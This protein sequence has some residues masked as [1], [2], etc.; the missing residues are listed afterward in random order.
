[1]F[2]LLQLLLLPVSQIIILK[3]RRVPMVLHPLII[4]I[5]IIIITI[6]SI[7]FH[8][9]L[10]LFLHLILIWII[11]FKRRS[12]NIHRMLLVFYIIMLLLLKQQK[13]LVDYLDRA[14]LYPCK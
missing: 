5:I 9:Q 1:M 13:I 14:F 8:L 6:P 4:I 12:I 10:V 2:L 3:A 7:I 11:G